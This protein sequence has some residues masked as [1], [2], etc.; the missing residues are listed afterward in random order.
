MMDEMSYGNRNL[1]RK[2]TLQSV[3]TNDMDRDQQLLEKS[4]RSGVNPY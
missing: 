2:N 4:K 3:V 1:A